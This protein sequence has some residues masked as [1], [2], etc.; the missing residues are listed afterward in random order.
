MAI[1]I[2]AFVATF[3]PNINGKNHHNSF[4]Q[5]PSS[6]P[7]KLSQEVLQELT[8]CVTEIVKPTETSLEA[9]QVASMQC[10][11]RVIML[12]PDG[13][14]RPDANQRMEALLEI[15]GASIPITFS[16]GEGSVKLQKL[17]N[18]QVFTIPVTVAEKTRN[19]L[20]D[21]GASNSI[22]D[23]Q[24]AQE[25]GLVGTPIPND[26]LSY[27]VVG[28]D[29][30]NINANVY[31]LPT[32]KVDAA[33][34]D[35]LQGMGLPNMAI[36]GNLSGVL[37]LDFLKSFDV[38]INPQNLQLK[39]LPA[40]SSVADAIPLLG[41]MGVMLTEVKINGQGP[42]I[43]LLDTGADLMVLSQV[44][45]E[46]LGVDILNAEKVDVLGFCGRE[47]AHKVK[48]SRVSIL[49]HEVKNLDSVVVNSQIF[50]SLGIDGII[51]H[52]FLSL[53]RQHWRFDKS[54]KLGFPEGGSL[55]L[56]PLDN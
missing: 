56:T 39:L 11:T 29:C 49:Q 28:D 35:G 10:T 38:I 25:L 21:T 31:S 44:L 5:T 32:L 51:G 1:G 41:R 6:T 43:F 30:S 12:A 9:L 26:L 19:F 16:Q 55:F 40:S 7:S 4:A 42:F 34:V 36:P 24:I 20:L 47:N 15:T 33:T 48:L 18:S 37:G 53:Y 14:F 2:I 27:F 13:S 3:Q 54:N 23:S 17:A 45:A 52:N 22:L 50:K 46:Q 8:K